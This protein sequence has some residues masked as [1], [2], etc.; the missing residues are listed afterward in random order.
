MRVGNPNFGKVGRA[1]EFPRPM[2]LDQ[3]GEEGIAATSGPVAGTSGDIETPDEFW[4]VTVRE[5]SFARSPAGASV[6][7]VISIVLGVDVQ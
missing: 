7:S 5:G 2:P 4:R 6:T 1:N 3:R